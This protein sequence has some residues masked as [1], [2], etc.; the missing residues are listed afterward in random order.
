[1]W[2]ILSLTF[3]PPPLGLALSDFHKVSPSTICF[4]F[5]GSF[6]MGEPP[7]AVPCSLLVA[8]PDGGLQTI[9]AVLLLRGKRFEIFLSSVA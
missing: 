2:M 6:S 7:G 8:S 3:P 1:M 9:G 4:F 5:F